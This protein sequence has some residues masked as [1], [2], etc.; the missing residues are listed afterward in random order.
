MRGGVEACSNDIDCFKRFCF[1]G[2]EIGAERLGRRIG[3]IWDDM[4]Y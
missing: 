4:G 1:A 2:M 3:K